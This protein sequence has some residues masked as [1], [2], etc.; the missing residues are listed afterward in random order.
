MKAVLTGEGSDELFGG[1]DIFKEAKIRRFL[2]VYPDSRLRPIL[3]RRLYP[4]QPALAAQSDAYREAFFG[5]TRTDCA[6]PVFSHR[7]RWNLTSRLKM[8]YSS[9]V[10]AALGRYD[11]VDELIEGL[12][13]GFGSWHP[14]SQA[15]YLET[16]HL[17][18]GYILSSQ[19]DR[20]AMAHS[21]EGRFPFLDAHVARFAAEL[22]PRLKMKV[23]NEKHLLKRAA[24]DLVPPSIVRR[25]KQPYRAPGATAFFDAEGNSPEYVLEMLSPSRLRAAGIFDVPAVGRLVAKGRAGRIGSVKDHMAFVGILS[26][27]LFADRFLSAR[28][29]GSHTLRDLPI[30]RRQLLVRSA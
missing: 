3:L 24:V 26:T 4:Y 11:A 23:L 16:A 17:L 14:F 30:H 28:N 13:S 1:Y 20:M 9:D 27:Q 7:P 10:R 15:E 21:V 29:H 12:P 5:A 25:P 2:T 18:P 6:D 8:F 19:G 22:P